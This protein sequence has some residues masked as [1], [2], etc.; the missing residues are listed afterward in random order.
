[1]PILFE[2]RIASIPFLGELATTPNVFGT[3]KIWKSAFADASFATQAT[4]FGFSQVKPFQTGMQ[5]NSLATGI[6]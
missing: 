6:V 2:F 5:A 3:G 4:V 1:L